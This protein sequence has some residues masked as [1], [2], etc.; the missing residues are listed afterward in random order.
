[1]YRDVLKVYDQDCTIYDADLDGT[2]YDVDNVIFKSNRERETIWQFNWHVWF[3]MMTIWVL[4]FVFTCRGVKSIEMLVGFTYPYSLLFMMV[5]LLK[6]ITLGNGVSEGV[7]IY[8]WGDPKK[9]YDV[10]ADLQK[11]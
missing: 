10:W 9:E 2:V 4:M 7:Y 1:M 5:L 3:A 6:A 11:S 8:L